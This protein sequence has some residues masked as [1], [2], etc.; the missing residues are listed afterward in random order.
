MKASQKGIDLIKKFEGCQLKAYQCPAG[1]WTIGYG[2]TFY[3]DGSKV[4]QGDVISQERANSLLLNLLSKFEAIVNK[5]IQAIINQNQFDALVSYVWNT[6][7]SN[8]LYSLIN[9][10]SSDA[11]IRNWF[12]TKYITGGG[13]V[14][15]GLVTRREAEADLYFS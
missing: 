2:N 12:E 9:T 13:K 15:S 6:G 11:S 7:G 3:E 14:L 10:K 1:I 5:N 4:K 8:T